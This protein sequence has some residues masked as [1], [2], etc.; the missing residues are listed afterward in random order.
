[1]LSSRA[2]AAVGWFATG[3]LGSLPAADR[4]VA[5]T[6][7]PLVASDAALDLLNSE[8]PVSAET[9]TRAVP[10]SRP[11]LRDGDILS[12]KGRARVHGGMSVTV[13]TGTG[14]SFHGASGWV[15]YHDP[16]TG[17][18]LSVGYSRMSGDGYPASYWGDYHPYRSRASM[19]VLYPIWAQPLTP[20]DRAPAPLF[21]PGAVRNASQD[22]TAP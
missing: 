6:P 7:A 16:V 21:M 22:A 1:M 18:T 15:S 9:Y 8:D 20:A 17:L 14:G 4:E 10:K 5:T 13:G 3:L 12:E 2:I 19:D 11:R